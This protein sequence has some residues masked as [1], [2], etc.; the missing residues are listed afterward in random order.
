MN[1]ISKGTLNLATEKIN[2][3][4]NT[5]ARK[6]IGISAGD[7]INPYIKVAGTLAKPRLAL[8]APT[9][10]VTTGAAVVTFGVSMLATAA[11]RRIFRKKDPCG[12]ALAEAKKKQA[13][14]AKTD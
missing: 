7:F 14:A 10:A 13:K 5:G 12:A 8:D 1:I 6:G 3:N 9:A 11:A 4:F 2:L